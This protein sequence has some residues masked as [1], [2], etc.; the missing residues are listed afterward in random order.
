MAV[1]D[2]GQEGEIET[3]GTEAGP[4]GAGGTPI[5]AAGEDEG[6]AATRP[7]NPP[8]PYRRAGFA[9]A[10]ALV[11]LVVAAVGYQLVIPTVHVE[12]G[13][14][15]RLVLAK[16]G[17]AAFDKAAPQAG[18]Q[19][20]TKTGLTAMTA[21]VKHS[22]NQTG[23]YSIQWVPT[24]STGVGI[25]AF[26]LPSDAAAA[27][28]FAQLRT[29]QLGTG[30]FAS[31]GLTRSSTFTVSAVPGSSGAVYT[32][33]PKA[34]AAVPG[35]AVTAFRSGR[36]VALSDAATSNATDKAT[37]EAVTAAEYGNLRHLG[38]GL[39][40]SVTRRPALATGLWVAGAVVLAAIVA[41]GPVGRRRRAD[42]RRRAYE[43][44]MANQVVVGRRV[45]VKHR[46]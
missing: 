26:L 5:G 31:S 22:P 40:L 34:S 21:A 4:D 25:V 1:S 46:R 15:A 35:L 37:V 18:E 20:D 17:V 6:E 43:E 36:V 44:M 29:Q 23:I 12:R 27:S 30:S 42:K 10:S 2:E 24:Q 32:A 3:P 13:R 38:S 9:V 7:A 28:T 8:S 14:L 33:A 39:S 16:P 11:V 41:L 19:D 45:I